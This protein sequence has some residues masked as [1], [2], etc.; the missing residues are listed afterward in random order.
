LLYAARTEQHVWGSQNLQYISQYG[1]NNIAEQMTGWSRYLVDGTW[2]YGYYIQ[3]TQSN[4]NTAITSQSGD[5]NEAY[6][7]QNGTNNY[8][9][10]QQSGSGNIA[11]VDQRGDSHSSIVNQI[12]TG[13]VATVTQHN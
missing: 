1:N 8:S 9:F 4:D 3:D 10:I 7:F 2:V 5:D 13:N 11:T 12:G 6:Q